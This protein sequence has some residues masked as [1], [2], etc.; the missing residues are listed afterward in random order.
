MKKKQKATIKIL[1][2]L[3]KNIALIDEKCDY[4]SY[5][6]LNVCKNV[7][8][9]EVYKMMTSY[10][11][12]WLGRLFRIRDFL[13]KRVGIRSINGFDTLEEGEPDIGSKVHFFTIIEK[14]RDTLTLVVRDFHLDVCVSIRI[15]ETN[16]FKEELFIITSVKNHNIWGKLYML[17]VSIIHPYIVNKLLKNLN[18]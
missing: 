15:I 6:C 9:Y 14:K 17:P 3:L 18:S 16:D 1:K 4:L 10:Q 8:A 5:Q 12:K 7:T 13:G 2:G 11:P